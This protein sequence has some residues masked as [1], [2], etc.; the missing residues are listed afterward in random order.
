MVRRHNYYSR[1]ILKHHGH[2]SI[3]RHR[4]LVFDF[5]VREQ[6]IH[7]DAS[8]DSKLRCAVL[9]KHH[10][11][12]S[13]VSSLTPDARNFSRTDVPN[14]PILIRRPALSTS[15][16]SLGFLPPTAT[17]LGSSRVDT[18]SAPGLYSL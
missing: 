4:Q 13:I 6:R 16:P 8:N 12:D 1:G 18:P 5:S 9:H 14:A 3:A 17:P 11:F 10:R 15:N 7:H 2:V